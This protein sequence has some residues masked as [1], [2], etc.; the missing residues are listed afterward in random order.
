LSDLSILVSSFDE[1]KDILLIWHKQHA[2]L[3]LPYEVFYGLNYLDR[4]F[5]KSQNTEFNKRILYS[6][7]Y[8]WSY[9]LKKWLLQIDSEYILLL[10]DDHI[11][12][13]FD[14]KH[15]EIILKNLKKKNINFSQLTY[16]SNSL[17]KF[18]RKDYLF[19][20]EL[21]KGKYSINLQPS[22]WKKN[23]LLKLLENV[24]SAWDFEIK[25]SLM[26]NKKNSGIN[27]IFFL[28]KDILF[29]EQYI[30]RGKYYPNRFKIAIDKNLHHFLKREKV[31]LKRRFISHL[32]FIYKVIKEFS[33]ALKKLKIFKTQQTYF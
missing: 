1:V 18:L 23:S 27:A 12:K 31:T 19:F 28:S 20:G 22:I 17:T 14:Y 3:K 26:F 8:N 4:D 13:K 16:A 15:I 6:E 29:Y 21:P 9:S 10:L 25:S 2:S 7:S 30:E 32:G 5:I 11:I 24:E 33:K